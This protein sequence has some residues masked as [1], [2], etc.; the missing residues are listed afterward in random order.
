MSAVRSLESVPPSLAAST[1]ESRV[2][3]LDVDT[4]VPPSPEVGTASG[5]QKRRSVLVGVGLLVGLGIGGYW[6]AERGLEKTDNAQVDADVIAVPARVA[7]TVARVFFEENQHVAAGALLAELDPAPLA[8]VLAQAEAQLVGAQASAEA[9]DADAELSRTKAIGNRDIARANLQTNSMG[10]RASSD[11]ILEGEAQVAS[12]RARLAQAGVDL[13]RA[14]SLFAS[15]AFTKAQLDATDTAQQVASTALAAQSAHLSSLRL[16][17]T[18]SQ[19]RVVE[20]SAQLRVSDS[21]DTLV[22]QAQARAAVAHAQ[23]DTAKAAR[24][25]AALEL[26]YTKIVAPR[27]GVVSKKSIN[28]GQSVASGQ[29]IV[30]LVPEERWITANFKETQLAHMKAGQPVR[31]TL[32]AYP[33]LTL[34]GDVASFSGATGARFTLLPPDNATGN[35]TKVVQRVPVRIRVR[36]VPS[37][38]AL[39]P[40]MSVDLEVDT[41]DHVSSPQG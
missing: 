30:Q 15:G 3:E 19:S 7:G 28:A 17:K 39:R 5:T 27:A 41:N 22:R 37:D 14:R 32:D 2:E 13:E 8:A 18:Q 26:A 10:A 16:A 9:A 40:G 23:V 11:G 34:E 38:V 6:Y 1:R 36:E 29:S 31:F 33:G 35:F 4:E 20:A 12:A 24:D 21:V 25:R